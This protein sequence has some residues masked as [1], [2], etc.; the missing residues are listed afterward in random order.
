M[1]HGLEQLTERMKF[2]REHNISFDSEDLM[3]EV[4]ED[5]ELYSNEAFAAVWCDPEDNFVKDYYVI[6]GGEDDDTE[7]QAAIDADRAEF[8]KNK[9]NSDIYIITLLELMDV[10]E[11]QDRTL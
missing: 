3:S 8:S 5:I 11:Y 1:R 2:N 4:A 10:L 9:N 6:V 7:E